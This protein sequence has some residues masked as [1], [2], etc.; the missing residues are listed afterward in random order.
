MSALVDVY[1]PKSWSDLVGQDHII[2]IFNSIINHPDKYPKNFILNGARGTGKTSTVNI[3]ANDLKSRHGN[4]SYYEFDCTKIS[5][6]FVKDVK[7]RIDNQ[8]SFSKDYKILVFDEIQTSS[9]NV[10][11]V[12]LKTLEDNL[13]YGT[14]DRKVYFFFLTTNID[15]IIDTVR[16]R[17]ISLH[18]LL[19]S[20]EDIEKR[21][22]FIISQEKMQ[23]EEK[24][25]KKIV[26][27]SEGHMREAIHLLDLYRIVEKEFDMYI[28]DSKKLLYT[29]LFTGEGNLNEIVIFPVN[30]LIRDLNK[31]I[32]GFVER[33]VEKEFVF[34]TKFLRMYLQFKNN[35]GNIDDFIAVLKILQNFIKTERK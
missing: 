5:K 29:N 35:I 27:L 1:S 11:S 10:Q 30:I 28:L 23:I 16:S 8:F 18:Y 14:N 34:T 22:R 9:N 7:D 6:D 2:K 12:F 25:I 17:C 19:L 13:I 21:I 33:F 15:E 3:F 31:L 4:V 26:D 20:V 24:Y 32:L